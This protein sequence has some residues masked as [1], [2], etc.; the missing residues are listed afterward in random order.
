M[1][2]SVYRKRAKILHAMSHPVRLQI[3]E[4]LARGPTCVCDLIAHT[5]RRQAYVSQHLM[6]LR[7]AGVVRRARVGRNVQYELVQPEITKN[8]LS[9]ML[10]GRPCKQPSHGE[11][12]SGMAADEIS[13]H[14]IPREQI[15]WQPSL[16]GERCDGCGL[17][18]T[19][20]AR[21]VFAFDYEAG[22]PVVATPKRCQVGCTACAAVCTMNAIELPSPQHLQEV[23]RQNGIQTRSRSMLSAD[24][25]HYDI[26]NQAGL[27]EAANEPDRI[28]A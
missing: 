19:S 25:V 7:Q 23:I 22:R 12:D 20:C 1:T 13:W 5:R 10:Q 14:G 15:D 9:C 26:K 27:L 4:R 11:Q 8:L 2:M 3:L 18:V 21:R 24:R 28:L 17:C 6:L 16:M